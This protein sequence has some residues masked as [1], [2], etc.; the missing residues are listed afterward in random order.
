[1]IVLVFVT[2]VGTFL[3]HVECRTV[4]VTPDVGTG[5]GEE[6]VINNV[7]VWMDILVIRM[8]DYVSQVNIFIT[9]L[10]NLIINAS[11][12]SMFT[13]IKGQIFEDGVFLFIHF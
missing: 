9:L 7:T 4:T 6:V 12:P 8:M 1:M 3:K 13:K 10:T 2:D 11:L 5:T